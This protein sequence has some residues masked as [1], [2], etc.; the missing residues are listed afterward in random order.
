MLFIMLPKKKISSFNSK[1]TLF[2]NDGIMTIHLWYGK[3]QN[4]NMH[5]RL[6]Q[7]DKILKLAFSEVFNCKMIN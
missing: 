3:I 1:L 7:I 6:L 2:Q 5:Q 4:F